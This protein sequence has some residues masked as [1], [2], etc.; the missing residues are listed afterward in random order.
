M[1]DLEAQV[2][3]SR[4]YQRLRNIKQL[5]L[6]HLVFPGVDYSRFS[7]SIG[8]CHVTGQILGA[9]TT[10]ISNLS[11]DADELQLYR[12]AGLLHDIG[13]YPFSHAM[14]EAI[15][16]YYAEKLL[17]P[18]TGMPEEHVP[19]GKQYLGHEEVGKEI[20]DSDNE[21]HQILRKAGVDPR[22]VYSIF[23]RE[24]PPRFA[25]L[26]SSD[27]DADR[28]DYL[29][30]TA[31]HTGIPYGSVDLPYLLSQMRLDADDRICLTE[32]A[33][34]AADHF[35]LGRYFDYSSVAFH[36]TVA[37]LELVLKDVMAGLLKHGILACS[38]SDIIQR[39]KA[40]EWSV[41]D[42]YSVYRSIIDLSENKAS[43]PV[44]TAKARS[45]VLRNPPRLVWQRE[46]LARR[47][48]DKHKTLGAMRKLILS[49]IKDWSERFSIPAEYWYVWD[50]SGDTLTKIGSRV[51]VSA[52][53]GGDGKERDR[54]EQ[55]IRILERDGSTS[56]EIMSCDQ[57]LMSVLA[58]QALYSLRVYLLFTDAPTMERRKEIE[59]VVA[60][61]LP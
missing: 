50:R 52:L 20:L 33:L 12:L 56:T 34:G 58:D 36:K 27:L 55:A 17:A 37:A 40:A 19:G 28:I 9:L 16:N 51:P 5:G 42:D 53:V 22:D 11:I 24:K 26:V 44:L 32:K 13:H 4:A 39:I 48:K 57:S 21:I 59:A 41:F 45:I 1:S 49:R 3:S 54:Y 15:S 7:H 61:D 10:N 25:N 60:A 18:K 23:L 6:A 8:V 2:I 38:A 46:Y 14:E 35:L 43:D 31:H 47:E 30:R 29:L